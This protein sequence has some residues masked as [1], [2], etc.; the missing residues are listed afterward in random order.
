MPPGIQLWTVKDAMAKDPAGTLQALGRMGYK[1]VE[2]AGWYGL[3]STQFRRWF[4]M[5]GLIAFP[6]TMGSA[7][8]SKMRMA[9]SPLRAMLE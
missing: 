1:R 6:P 5:R 8:S 9:A 2:A 7:I 4:A 3:T